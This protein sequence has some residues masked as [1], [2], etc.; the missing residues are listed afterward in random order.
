MKRKVLTFPHDTQSV[1]FARCE[2][3]LWVGTIATLVT[4]TCS[5]TL[6]GSRAGL[7]FQVPVTEAEF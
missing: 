2:S 6:K 4:S 5:F 3:L 1:T 7:A